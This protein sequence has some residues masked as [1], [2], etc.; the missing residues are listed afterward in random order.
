VLV[1][2]VAQV[3]ILIELPL[4]FAPLQEFDHSREDLTER[5]HFVSFEAPK[6]FNRMEPVSGGAIV[7]QLTGPD[8]NH[9]RD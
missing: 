8:A 7:A 6:D 5:H 9:R 1:Q 2:L 4:G 3:Q